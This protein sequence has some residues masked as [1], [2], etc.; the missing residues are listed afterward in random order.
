MSQVPFSA[1]DKNTKDQYAVVFATLLL[2][3]AGHETTE[4]SINNIIAKSGNSVAAY[5]PG[6]FLTALGGKN[7]GDFL[8]VSGGSGAGPAPA[9]GNA[10]GQAEAK[11]EEKKESEEEAN[12]SMGGL[13]S[14]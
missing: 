9:G 10:G 8:V 11:A 1:L 3:D 2:H 6:L 4:E 14:D 13:F 7:I 5:W 12:V